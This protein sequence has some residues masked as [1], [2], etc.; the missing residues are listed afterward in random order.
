MVAYVK[1]QQYVLSPRRCRWLRNE[2][3]QVSVCLFNK[4]RVSED[5]GAGKRLRLV[6]VLRETNVDSG[7]AE[8]FYNHSDWGGLLWE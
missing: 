2:G 4:Y 3:V 8:K 7:L 1:P 5:S 6:L